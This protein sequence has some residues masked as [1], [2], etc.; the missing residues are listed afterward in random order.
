MFQNS[1]QGP[2]R[3]SVKQVL[4][5]PMRLS[6][7]DIFDPDIYARGV[8]HEAFRLL[9]KEAPVFFQKEPGGRGYWALTKHEDLVTVS[10]DPGRFSSHRGGT[11]IQ[12]YPEEH[13]TSIQL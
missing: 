6:E 12:D 10:K 4:F 2:L 11:N 9:R 1:S 5:L 3:A 7:V 13:L 8:P